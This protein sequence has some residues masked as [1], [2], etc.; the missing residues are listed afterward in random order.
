MSRLRR[1]I[2]SPAMIVALVALFVAL[3]GAAYAG[4]TLSNNTVRSATIVNGQV[5]TADLANLAVTNAKI[6]NNAVNAAKVKNSSLTGSDVLDGSLGAPDLAAGAVTPAKIA[7]IPSARAFHNANQSVPGNATFTS[8][9]LN[10]ER[11]DTASLHRTDI[12]TSRLT[13]SSAGVYVLN[14]NVTWEQ[15][16]TGARELNIRKNGTTIVARVVQAGTAG[17][18][19]TDQSVTT[20]AQLAAGDFV[21]VVVRQNSAVALNVLAAPDFSPEFAA[22]WIAPA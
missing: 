13:V 16:A 20:L 22:S 14:A 5:K 19:T 3:G 15:N 17:G 7:G 12:D 1:L 9:A 6:K 11:F 21:E 2:P 18:N 8:I 4:V 10:S